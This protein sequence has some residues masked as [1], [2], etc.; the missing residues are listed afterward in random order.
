M[1]HIDFNDEDEYEYDEDEDYDYINDRIID[2]I[3]EEEDSDYYKTH[4]YFDNHKSDLKRDEYRD[5]DE[6]IITTKIAG[7]TYDNRQ[8]AVKKLQIGKKITFTRE[9]ENLYDHNAIAVYCKGEQLG[10]VPASIASRVAPHLDAGYLI[11]GTVIEVYGGNGYNYGAKI[12]IILK[13]QNDTVGYES[14]DTSIWNGIHN[15]EVN[16]PNGID[17]L[18]EFVEILN[19]NGFHGSVDSCNKDGSCTAD[20]VFP[21]SIP[22]K[23]LR[24]KFF[25]DG[26][27]SKIS[28]CINGIA[29][30][31][32]GHYKDDY[33]FFY[34]LNKAIND[35]QM[36]CRDYCTFSKDILFENSMCE[37]Y[38]WVDI[39][40]V[41]SF[42][43]YENSLNDID[44]TLFKTR[45]AFFSYSIM[46]DSLRQF[47]S[48]CVKAKRRILSD[49]KINW[50]LK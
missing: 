1:S 2:H 26:K 24:I 47:I 27:L 34:C 19:A 39:K 10:Y 31:S 46:L 5:E 40:A 9:P 11:S 16:R 13:R 29:F 3:I 36:D 7:V 21:G 20:L 45:D 6:E 49:Y 25:E 50:K 32:G 43:T 18:Y 41:Y 14:H 22:F 12:K 42:Y 35:I 23:Y 33:D 4:T 37:K 48:S 38:F 30:F 44:R 28:Y 15:Y 17:S 8:S